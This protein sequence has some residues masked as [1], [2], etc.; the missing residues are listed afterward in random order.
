MQSRDQKM[1]NFGHVTVNP[2]P[3]CDTLGA[4]YINFCL[5]E[6]TENISKIICMN[7]YVVVSVRNV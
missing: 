6:K 1:E 3:I 7:I 2:V 4:S 5:C